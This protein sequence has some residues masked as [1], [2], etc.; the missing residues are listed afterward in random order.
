[1][2]RFVNEELRGGHIPTT[3]NFDEAFQD[4]QDKQQFKE[5]KAFASE[6]GLDADLL[7]KSLKEYS[8]LKPE[9]IPFRDEISNGCVKLN[10]NISDNSNKELGFFLA[11]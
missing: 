10:R 4:W 6:W 3:S 5:V 9:E 2:K 1:M 11:L 8:L 7:S